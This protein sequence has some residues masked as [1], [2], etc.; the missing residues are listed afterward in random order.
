VPAL[1]PDAVAIRQLRVRGSTRAA[2]SVA[3]IRRD[4]EWADWPTAP[5]ESWVFVRRLEVRAS[6]LHVGEALTQC[7]RVQLRNASPHEVMRFAGL[8]Q[9]LA[10]LLADLVTGRAR[11]RWYWQ[12]W[13]AL[14]SLPLPNA[15]AQ[16][17]AEHLEHLPAVCVLLEQRGALSSVWS[18]LDEQGA[19][20][21]LPLLARRGRFAL[22]T[23]KPAGKRWQGGHE[24][25]EEAPFQLCATVVQRWRPV[26]AVSGP[27][28][29][30]RV[31]ALLLLGQEV[32]PLMLQHAPAKLLAQ[33]VRAVER[34]P[35]RSRPPSLG[36]PSPS[37]SW[38]A[39]THD[40][41]PG[42]QASTGRVGEANPPTPSDE[43]AI[44]RTTPAQPATPTQVDGAVASA[45]ADASAATA[46]PRGR[47]GYSHL[48][49]PPAARTTALGKPFSR[50]LLEPEPGFS[51]V[52]T[53]QGGLLYLLNALN[54]REVQTL[55]ADSWQH[56]P[57]G[58]GWLYRLGQT[59]ELDED[60]A[61]CAFLASQLGLA[62]RHELATLPPLPAAA[63]LRQLCLRWYG[64]A[65][66]WQPELLRVHA[67]IRAS[68]S[69]VDLHAPLAEVR[70]QVRLAGLDLNPGWLPW[71]GRVVTFHYN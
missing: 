69:H 13:S 15:L 14:F 62:N 44:A 48:D 16:L 43:A 60:D 56:M 31:V 23:V 42:A 7:A 59:L 10:A 65:G 21:L 33:L 24:A 67:E 63:E 5:G 35:S 34:A 66:L 68:P 41:E 57:H 46:A 47:S 3:R 64:R 30:R 49:V 51:H 55:M 40:D 36:P 8:S 54:R 39:A 45:S 26:L 58:W 28:E 52:R 18:Q 12:S 4:L 17:F 2:D 22:P 71:L 38:P 11:G 27:S 70:M 29:A 32:A 53:S 9:L 25:V 1:S 37:R 61:I 19:R 6:L 20:R 50:E